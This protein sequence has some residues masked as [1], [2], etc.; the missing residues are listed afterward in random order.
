ME[1]YYIIV[2]FIIGTIFGSFF[3]VVGYRLPK[4]KSIV[5]PPSHC[6]NCNNKLTPKEL[7]PIISYII[8]K[9]KCTHCKTKIPCFYVIFE[10]ITGILFALIYLVYGL[11]PEIII[12]L[13]FISM[14]IIITISDYNY[15]IINVL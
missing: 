14:L 3:N 12:P 13:T 11:T 4:G 15:M 6:P 9:G 8:Q 1:I 10:L 7:I 2:F 5:F